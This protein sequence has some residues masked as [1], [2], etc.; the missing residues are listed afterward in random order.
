MKIIFCADPLDDRRPDP[1][2]NAEVST[3]AQLGLGYELISYEAL[4]DDHD[5]L[6]AVRRIPEYSASE[7]GIYRGWM[8]KPELYRQLYTALNNRGITLI[9]TPEAYTHCH[10]LPEAYLLIQAYT[11]KSVWL[12][13]DARAPLDLP[14]VMQVLEV[15]GSEPVVVK[16]YVKSQK[17]YWNEAFFIPSAADQ[18]AVERVVRRFMEL[19]DDDLNQGLVF[20]EYV[21]LETIGHHSQS[22]MPLTTEFRTFFLDGVPVYSTKYWEEGN[23]P[24][25]VPELHD[26]YELGKKI[27]S[28]FFT[29][30]VAKRVDGGWIIVELGDAQVSGLPENANINA[31]YAAIAARI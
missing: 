28:R 16:D 3:V 7:L 26:F 25:E 5:P 23:Y 22:G 24:I 12:E 6:K 2:Y 15:F 4:V 20:R 27:N 14:R 11:P 9:N 30:D 13:I 18:N 1:A 31:F 17:H 10:Y 29:M 8:L 19:Q 21:Q